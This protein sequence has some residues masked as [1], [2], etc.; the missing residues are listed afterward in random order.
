MSGRAPQRG[1]EGQPKSFLVR[2]AGGQSAM[3]QGGISPVYIHHNL[4]YPQV[5]HDNPSPILDKLDPGAPIGLIK[6]YPLCD[7]AIAG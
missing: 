5:A 1:V 3:K 4:I 6:G 2:S 7:L